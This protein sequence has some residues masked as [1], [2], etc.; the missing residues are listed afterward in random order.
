LASNKNIG[1]VLKL[2]ESDILSSSEIDMSTLEREMVIDRYGRWVNCKI[3]T[4]DIVT[5]GLRLPK[6]VIV[7]DD[8]LRSGEN[9]PDIYVTTENK[10][11]IAKKL[12]EIGI[13][14]IE[15]GYVGGIKE[16]FEL[17]RRLRKEGITMKLGSHTRLWNPDFKSE[18]D[19]AIE[20]GADV[21][22]I[23]G[24]ASHYM[25]NSGLAPRIPIDKIPERIYEC[26]NYAKDRGM[27]TA[28]G[29]VDQPTL[30]MIHR[31][32][33]VAAEAGVDRAYLYDAKGWLTPEAISFLTTYIKDVVGS[34]VQIAIHCHDDYG[35]ATAN[36]LEAVKAGAEVV[37]VVVNGLGHRVGNASLEQV[38][39]AL[40]VLYNVETGIELNKLVEI[41]KLVEEI[42]GVKV[43]PDLPLVGEWAYHY[44]G[45][46][47][48]PILTGQWFVFENIK[49][50]TMGLNRILH[51]GPT[52]MHRGRTG[53]IALKIE[54]MGLSCT[55]EQLDMVID[56]IE[57]ILKRKR[58]A[59]ESEV[60]E[61]IRAVIGGLRK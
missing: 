30:D 4:L 55:D 31:C 43:P 1:G 23:I 49:A 11:R 16:H 34:K 54:K 15:V 58:Y 56:K 60:E 39:A 27:F 33:A 2:K 22:N 45:L 42:Y 35:L 46:H 59:T 21:I 51:F 10:V 32:Y 44:A 28:F 52:A 36:T 41:S 5:R 37:D 48:I 25:Y 13:P 3:N 17:A 47:L 19:R 29:I 7:K 61:V 24:A 9:T 53:P 14:E 20:G 50:E 12:E 26:I 38:V 8:T 18:I 40:T 6:R 57:E